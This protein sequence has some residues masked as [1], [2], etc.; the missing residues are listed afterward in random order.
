V[1]AALPDLPDYD[2]CDRV[3]LGEWTGVR[4]GGPGAGILAAGLALATLLGG[5]GVRLRRTP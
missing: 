1:L 4:R 2:R 5:A 3:A